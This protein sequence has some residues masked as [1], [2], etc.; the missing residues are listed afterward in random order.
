M[1]FHD[2]FLE[3]GEFKNEAQKAGF[4]IAGTQRECR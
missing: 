4:E 1:Q 2:D 3:I